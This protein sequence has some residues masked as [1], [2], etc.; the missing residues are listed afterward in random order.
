MEGSKVVSKGGKECTKDG[1]TVGNIKI[2]EDGGNY[3]TLWD[4]KV[5]WAGPGKG[6]VIGTGGPSTAKVGSEPSNDVGVERGGRKFRKKRVKRDAVEGF[7][8]ING[9]SCCSCRRFGIIK[10][11]SYSRGKR[12]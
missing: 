12:K 4:S 5:D 9:Y 1:W 7:G 8:K 6:V 10:A 3:R 2:E 11:F